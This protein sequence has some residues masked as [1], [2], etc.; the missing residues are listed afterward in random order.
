MLLRFL[1][2]A[3]FYEGFRQMMFYTVIGLLT[4][5]LD[6]IVYAVLVYAFDLHY[7]VANIVGVLVSIPVGFFL[8]RNFNFLTLDKLPLRLMSFLIVGVLGMLI[9]GMMLYVCIDVYHFGKISSKLFSIVSVSLL[10]FLLN[11]YITFKPITNMP[12][13]VLKYNR[14]L[15]IFNDEMLTV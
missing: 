12:R 4:S 7:L 8:N 1:S 9:T 11:K 15:Q 5:V 2:L 10:Q 6:F 13:N 14:E 3:S